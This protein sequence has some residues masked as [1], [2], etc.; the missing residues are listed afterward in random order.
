MRAAT[1]SRHSYPRKLAV[2]NP[3][4]DPL[5]ALR[6]PYAQDM[7]NPH[8]HMTQLG[9][10]ISLIEVANVRLVQ[11]Q[12]KEPGTLLL[13]CMLTHP[14]ESEFDTFDFEVRALEGQLFIEPLLPTSGDC[15]P[16]LEPHAPPFLPLTP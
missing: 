9:D 8:F 16:G 13:R 2:D 3:G 4:W 7:P 5:G 10:P 14:V 12:L 6:G 15:L 1:P 11:A